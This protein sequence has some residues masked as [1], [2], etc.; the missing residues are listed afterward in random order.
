MSSCCFWSTLKWTRTARVQLAARE[1][2]HRFI[3]QCTV[4]QQSTAKCL[5]VDRAIL[6]THGIQ[7]TSNSKSGQVALVHEI[8]GWCWKL[9]VQKETATIRSVLKEEM[10]EPRNERACANHCWEVHFVSTS[11]ASGWCWRTAAGT[12]TWASGG[13]RLGLAACTI[14]VSFDDFV[15]MVLRESRTVELTRGLNVESTLNLGQTR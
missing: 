9:A 10:Q 14:V 6:A 2:R 1:N 4:H 8:G 7:L 13:S 5:V 15:V 3:Y 11:W 12:W